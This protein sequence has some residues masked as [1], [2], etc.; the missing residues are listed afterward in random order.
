[1]RSECLEQPQNDGVML[2]V[3]SFPRSGTH[4]LIDFLRRNFSEFHHRIGFFES[5]ESLY[6]NLDASS[7]GKNWNPKALCRRNVIV[8][9]HALPFRPELHEE[10]G[11]IANGRKIEILTPVREVEAIAASYLRFIGGAVAADHTD[12]FFRNGVRPL[13]NMEQMFKFA[14]E[15]AVLV[16]VCRARGD[17]ESLT[18]KLAQRYQ[19]TP[20]RIAN[21]LPPRRH[22]HGRI[23]ELA[24]RL[25]G[26]PSSEVVVPNNGYLR[27]VPAEFSALAQRYDSAFSNA[28]INGTALDG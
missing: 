1:M 23:G 21:R 9:T 25:K 4:F 27:E 26:R 24:S 28:V 18:E 22:S 8:K 19:L 10:L 20:R 16:D 15:K 14:L 11:K 7:N 13:D 2:V 12:P 5:S 17:P 3:C 6:F